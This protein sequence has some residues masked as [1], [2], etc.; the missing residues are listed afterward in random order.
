MRTPH[1]QTPHLPHLHMPHLGRSKAVSAEEAH[2][3]H[4]HR[5]AFRTLR[6][7]EGGI[8]LFALALVVLFA[9]AMI[10]ALVTATG[11]PAYFDRWPG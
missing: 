5:P 1:L 6:E 8:D 2:H 7:I 10:Y 3:H 9:V 4:H 11:H